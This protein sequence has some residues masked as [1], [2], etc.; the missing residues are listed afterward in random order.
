MPR[1]LVLVFSLLASAAA[2]NPQYVAFD[3]AS[4]SSTYSA[5]NLAGSPAFAAQQALS[6]GSGYWCS[7]GNHAPGQSVT[8]TGVL[9]SR[10]VALGVKVD[11]AY[12]PG[13]VKI[14]TSSDGANFEEAMCWQPSSRAEVAF[15]Q[16]VM[17]ATPLNVKAVT[18]A[19]RSPQSWGY[20]GINSAVLVAEPGP[21]MLVS[22]ITSSHGE[23]CLVSGSTGVSLESC[24]GAIAAG[25]G[26]EVLQLDRDGQIRSTAD[27]TC[28]TLADGD[29]IAGGS[30]VM[31]AC[32][33][34]AEA[35]DGRTVFASSP[36]GQL[37][38][39]R[40]GNF[41]LSMAGEG[42]D[43]TDIALGADAS[44]TSSNAQHSIQNAVDGDGNS[45]WASGSD[46]AS[47]VDVQ[48]D[49]GAAKQIQAVEIEWEYPAQAFDVQVASAGAW[50]GL[51]AATGNN[52]KTSKYLGPAASGSALRIRMTRPHPT[53]GSADGHALYGI[54][55]VRVLAK[56]ARFVVQDCGEAEDNTDAR[57]KFFMSAVPEFDPSAS[58]VAKQSAGLLVAAED[59]L[60][61][62]LAS[63]YAAL[64]S[65]A[66]CGFSGSFST[67]RSQTSFATES[68]RAASLSARGS[69]GQGDDG[70]AAAVASMASAAGVD[71]QGLQALVTDA[72]KTIGQISR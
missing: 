64:P 36:N 40:M 45:F 44:A 22:A 70:V 31:E 50:S 9:N 28:L 7:S 24:L 21:F 1:P 2:S 65:L 16:S 5:G 56:S 46:P 8:W 38:M 67:R 23:Q 17:F 25:D 11:W 12:G 72:R 68:Q 32:S 34:S 55:N 71:M 27:D 41:C 52:L 33:S 35:S 66:A 47:G 39:P 4:A 53:L 43:E 69:R 18:I 63:L 51:F 49:F 54:K 42:A 60:G 19:V 37:K 15:E 58:S 13:E 20:Y 26:R 14:L 48:L 10:R 62:L 57:D 30:L 6:G 29:T 59:R 61:S 3:A